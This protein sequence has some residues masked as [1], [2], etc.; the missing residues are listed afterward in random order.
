MQEE[1]R[2]PKT[3]AAVVKA[4][5]ARPVQVNEIICGDEMRFSSGFSE[6]DR[7]LGGGVVQGSLVLVGGDP[8]IGK[9]TLLLQMCGNICPRMSVL[10]VTGEESR[11]QLK[12]RAERLGISGEN[13]YILT[14]TDISI[15][16]ATIEKLL[17]GLVI[18]DS[19]QT[20]RRDDISSSVGSVSQVRECTSELMRVSKESGVPVMIVGHVNKEGALAG[21]KVMEHMVD[22]VLYFEGDRNHA[23]RI[24][25]SVK[26]RFGAT[27][28]IGVFEMTGT[29]LV[30]VENPSA[31]MLA[32]RPV[33]ISG[34]CVAC[35][36]EGTR[37]M[38][39]EVQA[40]VTRTAFGMPR[41][42]TDGIELNRM[43]LL[44]A[45]SEKRA[46]LL[47]SSQDIYLNVISGMRLEDTA[48]DLPVFLAIAS[49]YKDIPIPDDIVAIGEIGLAGEVRSASNIDSRISEAENLGFSRCIIPGRCRIA[50]KH[51]KIE[52]VPVNHI[53]QALSY[54][55]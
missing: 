7:V 26:N 33:K 47:L 45:V 41:R 19:I 4:E 24:L 6:L 17:P 28:E 35:T 15:I 16:T 51:D 10:Y 32:G 36:F 23:Y 11:R 34:T 5:A 14:E 42:I 54:L 30:Q 31:T 43:L 27:N 49:A 44:T 40:L 21:P 12:L 55:F 52:L 1:D 46:G 48:T 8:G 38:L 9:S 39:A 18:I 25:R 50:S 2:R 20:M 13:L 29:G 3:A 22:T 37:P 53:T